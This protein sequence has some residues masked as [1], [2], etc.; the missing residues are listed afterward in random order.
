MLHLNLFRK[1]KLRT[2][3]LPD[4]SQLSKLIIIVVGLAIVPVSS[5][6]AQQQ[7]ADVE[8]SGTVTGFCQFSNVNAGS[9]G[10]SQDGRTLSSSLSGGSAGSASISCNQFGQ[11]G[12]QIQGPTQATSLPVNLV[13]SQASA[14]IEGERPGLFGP[15]AFTRTA[16]TEG[17][18]VASLPAI[19]GVYTIIDADIEVNMEVTNNNPF[20]DGNYLFRVQLSAVPR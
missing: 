9:L 10:L 13:S 19:L 4:L 18:D 16:D 20:P 3:R 11:I 2:L 14:N 17:N 15:I 8:F 1:K 7:T 6:K 5:V 12:V